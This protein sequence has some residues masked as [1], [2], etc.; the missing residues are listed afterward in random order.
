VIVKSDLRITLL[1]R[2]E[3]SSQASIKLEIEQTIAEAR[4]RKE[5]WVGSWTVS[6]VQE[7]LALGSTIVAVGQ[8][9]GRIRA[10]LC[11]RPPGP[12]WE[13]MLVVTLGHFR[14]QRLAGTLIDGLFDYIDEVQSA[15]GAP[16]N[17]DDEVIEVG[18]EV[19]A[20]NLSALRCYG[21]CG[22][23]EQRRRKG[24][25]AGSDSGPSDAVLMSAKRQRN[26]QPR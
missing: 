18:L 8:N 20:D 10:F 5:A 9:D 21:N 15:G 7:E 6:A 24:Y 1:N 14:G 12:L 2:L 3:E 16:H 17:V 4:G 22:F 11:F 26:A 25:Y 19:S 13:I 23:I